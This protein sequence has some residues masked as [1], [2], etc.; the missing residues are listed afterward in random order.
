VLYNS[1]KSRWT[2]SE[3]S[4][5]FKKKS[6]FGES[7]YRGIL[8][9]T[10]RVQTSLLACA[11]GSQVCMLSKTDSSRQIFI[12]SIRSSRL[13]VVF[14][15]YIR[16]CNILAWFALLRSWS[17][18]DARTQKRR[19]SMGLG[20]DARL[21]C[22]QVKRGIAWRSTAPR[23]CLDLA[24]TS[25]LERRKSDCGV[26]VRSG[27]SAGLSNFLVHLALGIDADGCPVPV[28]RARSLQKWDC[29]KTEIR[30][31][32][33]IVA[34]VKTKRQRFHNEWDTEFPLS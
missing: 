7:P 14:Q 8:T 10:S 4:L 6:I 26:L 16:A 27:S 23:D 22:E 24:A 32:N 18:V 20:I 9:Y 1:P 15:F 13:F 5:L 2:Y 34:E 29:N 21:C 3:L 12:F 28:T 31:V 19:G 25:H 11:K 33:Y 17:H 30:W